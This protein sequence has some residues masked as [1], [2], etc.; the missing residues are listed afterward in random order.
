MRNDNR[1][2]RGG[3]H[4][5]ERPQTNYAAMTEYY[6]Q[7]G[8][9]KREVFIQ[10]PKQIAESIRISRTN[11]RR[12]YDFVA[13]LRF[14][15]QM[16]EDAISVLQPGMGQLHRFVQYQSGRN[17]AWKEAPNFF[18]KHI[19]AVGSDPK[20]FEGFYQLF[21]SVMAYLRR[22]SHEEAQ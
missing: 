7:D 12:A 6:D 15:I 4:S 2:R 14:R 20:K 1:G 9:L 13:A 17:P 11:M 21:Q 16:G 19:D 22:H 18:H 5:R 3:D 10:W 8:R